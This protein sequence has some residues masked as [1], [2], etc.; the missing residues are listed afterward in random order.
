M[1]G[2]QLV[3]PGYRSGCDQWWQLDGWTCKLVQ[4]KPLALQ[5]TWKRNE[6]IKLFMIMHMAWRREK[7]GVGGFLHPEPGCP[8]APSSISGYSLMDGGQPRTMTKVHRALP[9]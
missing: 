6:K 8:G 2:L 4:T 5:S 3:A 9:P 1:L 7:L